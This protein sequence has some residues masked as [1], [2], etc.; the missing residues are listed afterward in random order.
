[1]NNSFGVDV[2]TR[3]LE[4]LEYEKAEK[5]TYNC[6]KENEFPPSIAEIRKSYD[7]IAAAEKHELGEIRRF[8]EQAR[9]FYPGCGEVG[10]GWKEF[11]A[12]AKTK[13]D[14]EKLQNLIISYVQRI[15]KTG[16]DVIDFAE[17]VKSVR[18]DKGIIT[19]DKAV[20]SPVDERKQI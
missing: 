17:C 2:W 1:M 10:Y 15:D 14:A 13:E 16:G 4:D 8:Y 6:L 3:S 11:S 5:A 9:S 20:N 7:V 12:R 18:Y 19:T